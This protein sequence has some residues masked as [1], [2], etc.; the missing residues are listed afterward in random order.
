MNIGDSFLDHLRF[1]GPIVFTLGLIV[2]PLAILVLGLFHAPLFGCLGYSALLLVCHFWIAPFLSRTRLRQAGAITAYTAVLVLPVYALTGRLHSWMLYPVVVV[3]VLT[4]GKYWTTY[5]TAHQMHRLA[6]SKESHQGLAGELRRARY[7]FEHRY[8]LNI[9]VLVGFYVACVIGF[10]Q[11]LSITECL[12]S[13]A[14]YTLLLLL[15]S[16]LF[17]LARSAFLIRVDRWPEGLLIAPASEEDGE[18]L[19][20][21]ILCSL[22]SEEDTENMPPERMV[23]YYDR[24]GE[25]R[26]ITYFSSIVVLATFSAYGSAYTLIP[27]A[28]APLSLKVIAMISV[29]AGLLLIHIPYVISQKLL[30]MRL[31]ARFSGEEYRSVKKK[32]ETESRSWR[33]Q[34]PAEI[35]GAS[36][37]APLSFWL[38]RHLSHGLG[39]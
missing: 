4:F 19:D 23:D 34:G 25:I 18:E 15:P 7:G 9:V 35:L 12:L 33:I 36:V 3:S 28:I 38:I 14:E 37:F 5:L 8:V 6:T 11:R 20:K 39:L 1:Y 16:C 31:T 17:V 26:K 32:L 24:S 22:F 13:F 10:L 27:D 21:M 2:M 29:A 30:L